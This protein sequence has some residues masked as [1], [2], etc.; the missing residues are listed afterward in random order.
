MQPLILASNSPRRA[1]LLTQ[2]GFKFIIRAPQT[3]ETQLEAGSDEEILFV[4]RGNALKK[5][6]S[7]LP[8]IEEGIILGGDTLVVTDINRVVG[9]PKTENEALQMLQQLSG[10]THR[11]ISAVAVVNVVTKETKLDHTWTKL[12]FHNVTE[13]ELDEYVQTGEPLGK[14]GGYAIQGK[15]RE[16]VK[17]IDGSY[18]SVIGLPME[19]VVPLL[20]EVGIS[21]QRE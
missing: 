12:T 15:G 3:H 17:S 6:L 1:N 14:A 11:V 2:H 21:P 16:L 5:T 9:K 20:K 13:E 8:C 7:I 18:T 19:V 4:A 10:R